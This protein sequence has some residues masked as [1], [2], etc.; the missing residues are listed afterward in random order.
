M[1]ALSKSLNNFSFEIHFCT[2]T[3]RKG[4]I[5]NAVFDKDIPYWGSNTHQEA[6]D[7]IDKEMGINYKKDW[8]A[9]VH[10]CDV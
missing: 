9:Y 7:D 5:Y 3:Y 2:H 10:E 8:T 6:Y 1:P 4:E